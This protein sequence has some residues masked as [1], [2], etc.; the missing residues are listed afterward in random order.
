MT[1]S[2][3]WPLT[4]GERERDQLTR[5]LLDLVERGLHTKCQ[6]PSVAHLWLSED[7]GERDLASR[8]CEGCPLLRACFLSAAKS[9]ATFGVFGGRDFTT[10]AGPEESDPDHGQVAR[11]TS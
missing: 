5:A 11:A 6:G 1:G 3:T 7:Q 4:T 9:G 10:M 8:L 2:A